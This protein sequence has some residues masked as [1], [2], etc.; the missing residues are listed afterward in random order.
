[1]ST[2]FHYCCNF[3]KILIKIIKYNL[4]KDI[5]FFYNILFIIKVLLIKIGLFL[6]NKI[7]FLNIIINDNF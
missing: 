3:S 4:I 2:R 5:K 1:M 7:L 6:I